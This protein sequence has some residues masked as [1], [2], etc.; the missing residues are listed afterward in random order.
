MDRHSPLHQRRVPP[1]HPRALRPNY[2]MDNN[3]RAGRHLV[4]LLDE[5]EHLTVGRP[6]VWR[7]YGS[8]IATGG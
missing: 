5:P 7:Q 8:M 1:V 3:L 2:R 6:L 4:C